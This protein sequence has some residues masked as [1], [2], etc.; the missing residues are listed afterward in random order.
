MPSTFNTIDF[1]KTCSDIATNLG[2]IMKEKKLSQK[3]L[4]ELCAQKGMKVSQATISNILNASQNCS[5]GNLISICNALEVALDELISSKKSPHHSTLTLDD[6]FITDPSDKAFKG[7]LGTFKLYFYQTIGKNSD[8]LTGDLILKPDNNIC[9]ARLTLYTGQH[10]AADKTTAPVTKT[11]TGQMVISTSM[12]CAYIHLYSSDLSEVSFINFS[13]FY[14]FHKS[15]KCVMANAVTTSAGA[16]KRPT[17]HRI[18]ISDN[19]ISSALLP[20]VKGQLLL[21]EAEILISS[22]KLEAFKKNELVQPEFLDLLTDAIQNE[23]YYSV[24]EAK[25]T[26]NDI[27]EED[28]VKMI[29]LLRSYSIAPKY[30]KVSRK[31]DEALFSLLENASSHESVF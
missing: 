30:N 1:N 10:I 27:S 8:L 11:Y 21:N 14:L 5:L 19:K 25:L 20:Y 28:L 9:T 22:K 18:C 4:S 3:G 16:N 15:L 29:S 23:R 31:T 26:G 7:Y 17:I 6:G 13:H 24:T 2:R 12:R